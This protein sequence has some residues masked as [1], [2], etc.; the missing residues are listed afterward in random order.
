MR[1]APR[2]TRPP[3]RRT[4]VRALVATLAALA[5]LVTP[6]MAT[7]HPGHGDDPLNETF[8]ALVF[9]KTAGFRH[10]DSIEAG[11]AAIQALGAEH[12]FEVTATEDA[13]VFND[14]DL[15][16]YAVV[17]W[18]ST[19]GDVLNDGQQAAFERYIRAGGGYAGIHAASDTEYDWPW[20]GGLVGAYFASH[21]APQLATV[22]VEDPAHP[23]TAGLPVEWEIHDEW[24]DFRTNPRGNVHVLASLDETTYSGGQMGPEHPIS[25]CHDYDG[26][27][28]WYTGMGHG[29]ATFSDP[30]FLQHLLG[31]IQ[32]AAGAVPAD[33]A[34]SLTE[35]YEKV[36]LDDNT[37]NPMELAIAEDGRVFYIDRNG[38]V[39][40]VRADG[41]VVTA[42]TVPVYT[43]QE[44][45]MLGLALD[46][47][48]TANGRLYLYYSPAGSAA[49]DRV[50]RFTVTGDSLDLGSEEVLLEIDVQRQECCH[51]GGALEFDSQGNLY[52]ATGDITNPFASDGYSP[53][54]ERPGRANWDAQRTSA[55]SDNLN[56]KILRIT[57]QP[58]GG[59]TVPDGNLFPPGTA[60]TRAEIFA[61]GFRNPFTIGIDP[62]TDRL[63]VADYG[64]DASATSPTR[65]PDGRVEWNI[66]EE[67]GFYG[68]PYCVGA[69][70]PYHAYNFATGVAGPA[71]DCG[72][73]VND[74]PN[75]TGI[76]ELPPAIGAELWMGK[77]TTGVPEIGG[78]GA[79]MTSGAYAFDPDLDSAR[80]WP[81]YFDGKAVLGD[82][83]DG[84]MFSVQ[85]DE[86]RTR[87]A[88]V[89]RMLQGMDF[90]RPHAL[91]FGPDGALYVIEWGTGFGGGNADSGVYRI[92]YAKGDRAPVARFTASHTSGPLPLEVAFD[93]AGSF[94]PDGLPITVSWDFD[95]DGVQDSTDPAPTHTYTEAGRFTARLTVTDSEGRS[96]V[97]N[98]DITAGNSAPVIEVNAPVN[99][100]YFEFGDTI[101][102]EVTVTDAEDGQIDCQD[103]IVQPGLGHD[104]HSHGYEQYRGCSGIFPLPGD[105]GH[106]GANIF[107]TVTVTYTDQ[108]NGDAPPLTTQEVL[109]LQPKHR[110]A[111][112]FDT[113]GRLRSSTAGG[114]PGVIREP[115]GDT[116]GG[117]QN[118]GFIE[119]GDWW[120]WNPT[121]LTG[122]EEIGLRAASP[123]AGATVEVRT[124]DPDTGPTV[125]TVQVGATG[126]WQV[127]D[128]FTAP[129][130]GASTTTGPLYFVKTTGQLNVNWVTFI[131]RGITE[132]E[133]PTVSVSATPVTGIAPLEVAFTAE[134][135]DPEGDALEYAWTFGDGGTATGPTA[136]HTYTQAGSYTARATVT[137][138][139]GATSSAS[140]AI[141]VDR[142]DPVPPCL[143][144]RSDG[145]DGTELDRDRWTE[146]VRENQ[147]LAVRDGHLVLPLTA[148]DIYG[149]GNTGTPNIVLQ[150]LPD[151]AWEATAKLTLPAR[152]AYQQAGLIVY[153]DDD[154]YAKMVLQGRATSAPS[155][156]SRI[157]QF[158]R[159]E[160]GD[161]RE[162]ADSNTAAL[163]DGFPDTVWV[164]FT[165]DG[166]NLRAYYSAD[167][168]DFT[169]MPETKSLAGLDNPRIGLFA[170][171]NRDDA[172]PAT[173]LVDYFHFTPDD[174]ATGPDP[175]DAFEGTGLDECRWTGVV[176]PAPDALQVAGGTLRVDT[177]FGDIYA[178]ADGQ[179]ANLVLQP[180]P[181]G[182]WTIETRVDA[183]AFD[184]RYQ[185]AGLLVYADDT[186]YVKLGFVT[187]NAPGKRV[188]RAIELRAEAGD[189]VLR[190]RPNARPGPTHGVWHL[191]L[192]RTG[193]TYTGAYSADG[194]TWT[195]LAPVTNPA[196]AE[197]T[198][199]FGLFAFGA[200]QTTPKPA[201]FDHFHYSRE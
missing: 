157:F 164:R 55:N 147:D 38:A 33:C 42:G 101:A 79:A 130:S 47:E 137:D 76:R 29:A 10:G 165:S 69:N 56:G 149:T 44:F 132:N 30:Q 182:D 119:D 122:I 65:G 35:S 93:S 98:L 12:D 139:R 117:G 200:D 114:D 26:G 120:A 167:G 94:H 163:G 7:A 180:A 175:S 166:E 124:G 138:E 198:P 150:D 5:M 106:T 183:S 36:V 109:V 108:G 88:D 168:A 155:A 196:L 4:A 105:E 159:E 170:L 54:D 115:T 3:F 53:L 27:R 41:T 136:Q 146:V 64:P 178:E 34:A 31:G 72:A 110:E 131:G 24:Y 123:S 186:T 74:S 20:Y 102:Y 169:A 185:Q 141:R 52:I 25:W 15:A 21:P 171:A 184:E 145:F 17:I 6:G 121:N 96:A 193:D 66:V 18:L 49:V 118:I 112:H 128:D 125:A 14:Q 39:R 194:T 80:K 140:V 2:P 9:S 68:W 8:S 63:Y 153:G 45:G 197:S 32:S 78:S 201:L 133:R 13:A 104:D 156:A 162:V 28:S 86:T 99:G 152:R 51:A 61:M 151:G 84:R 85:P 67:P 148:T 43:G 129:V 134:A 57:P 126:D 90:L 144:G 23:S 195:S 154:N 70:T 179:P 19:T 192:T 59:Y 81:A 37:S 77:S 190:P 181:E 158:I 160:D 113:T 107:G 48:F 100:G 135:S 46:P 73:P 89:S 143:T 11:I 161:P 75:N 71:F 174:T 172:L 95:G 82:W 22:K 50:S 92:D 173:A 91:K 111:E 87:V 176:R 62:A 199:S 1:P 58:D 60:A 188:K 191:R 97:S 103:V 142:P 187:T 127:Y 189:V 116:A 177:S 40:V 83:N 16:R